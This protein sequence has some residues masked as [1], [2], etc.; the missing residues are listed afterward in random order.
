MCTVILLHRPHAAWPLIFAANRDEMTGRPWLPP[1]RHWP[2]RPQ[3]VGG[4]DV[5]AG[6]TWLAMNDSGLIAGVL[7]RPGSLGPQD[8]KKSRGELPLLALEASTL[9][10]AVA[11]ITSIDSRDY[12]SFN[13]VI[14]GTGGA[15]WLK[16]S[17]DLAEG[18]ASVHGIPE[19]LHMLTAHDLDDLESPRIRRHLPRFRAAPVPDPA[20]GDWTGWIDRLADRSSETPGIENGAMTIG[21][22]TGFATV[23]SSLIALANGG[24]PPIWMFAAGQPD[25]VSFEPVVSHT[26]DCV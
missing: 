4:Q 12:R 2:T 17:G 18:A 16:S 10:A 24:E 14:A 1:A 3:V 25:K 15:V 5:Q 11:R 26:M 23:S 9:D 7:N 19:G 21:G 20:A 13:M 6:G 8:G 22:S